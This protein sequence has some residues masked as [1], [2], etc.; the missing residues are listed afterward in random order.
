MDRFLKNTWY[1]A[2][3]ANELTDELLPRT[4]FGEKV[5]LYRKQDGSP[6]ALQDRC[7][8]RFAPLHLGKQH[9]DVIACPYHGLR[10]D[11]T[12][13]CVHNPHGD[14]KIPRACRI[15]GYAVVERHGIIWIWA[16]DADA[17]DPALIH[18]FSYIVEDG[19]KTVF[20]GTR[21]MANYELI[22]DNLM[23]ASHTQYVHEDLLGTEA[24]E[25]S[26]HEVVQEGD[27]VNSNYVVPDSVVPA[28]YRQYFPQDVQ[29]VVYSVRF[30]WHPPGLVRNSVSLEP[31]GIDH[32][33]V[34][35]TG[36]HL[37]TPETDT[38]THYFFAHTRNFSLDDVRV[39]QRTRRWQKLGLTD[40]DGPI[41]EAC[42]ANMGEETDLNKLGPVLFSIDTAAVRVRRV[43]EKL[44]R[45]EADSEKARVA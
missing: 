29:Q 33:P 21:V 6:A 15:K 18:D 28:A 7:P 25:K 30:R 45:S 24:F 20:G 43:L 26:T 8:H 4:L 12:G 13:E 32:P 14:G 44:I 11:S 38:T 10:F 40:Q 41:I 27:I 16:G 3:W 17:A 35:R 42:Q 23:D 39:D 19:R 31:I 22:A 9:G 34:H 1:V 5:V 36:T 37:M 2:A